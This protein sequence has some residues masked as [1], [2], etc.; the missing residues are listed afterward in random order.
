ME[1]GVAISRLVGDGLTATEARI[2]VENEKG[3]L[4]AASQ[5]AG[6]AGGSIGGTSAES[7]YSEF[8]T[9]AAAVGAFPYACL[10]LQ[11]VAHLPCSA[12]LLLRASRQSTS[13]LS[14]TL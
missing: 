14:C 11:L 7:A 4:D 1:L 8:L 13:H 9:S 3:E 5:A 6:R 10:A 2:R 12:L